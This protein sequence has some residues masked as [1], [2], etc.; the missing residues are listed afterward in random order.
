MSITSTIRSP[1]VD[2]LA[3]SA[4]RRR[5]VSKFAVAEKI[6]Y[7]AMDVIGEKNPNAVELVQKKPRN[8]RHQSPS[9]Q[10]SRHISTY[11]ENFARIGV[12]LLIRCPPP[13]LT[14]SGISKDNLH[15]W[16]DLLRGSPSIS[17][18]GSIRAHF[19]QIPHH[20]NSYLSVVMK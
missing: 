18:S 20:S 6:V 12:R 5:T 3:A 4:N 17:K 14:L 1:F 9:T 2:R 11:F 19:L 10:E 15:P 7:G 13:S 16:L 8:L